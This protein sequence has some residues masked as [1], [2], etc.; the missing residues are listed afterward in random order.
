MKGFS[1]I[2]AVPNKLLPVEFFTSKQRELTKVG[3]DVSRRFLFSIGAKY[4]FILP[5][6]SKEQLGLI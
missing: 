3:D 5:K 6:N 1:N 2:T 4:G